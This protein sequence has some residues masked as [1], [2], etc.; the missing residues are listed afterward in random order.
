MSYGPYSKQEFYRDVLAEWDNPLNKTKSD[1][2]NALLRGKYSWKSLRAYYTSP[3][4]HWTAGYRLY[5][6]DWKGCGMD[7][8]Y[9]LTPVERKEWRISK[10]STRGAQRW[11]PAM[12][13][14]VTGAIRAMRNNKVNI[15]CKMKSQEVDFSSLRSCK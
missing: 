4:Y 10:H 2:T 12:Q 15:P 5:R 7:S 9:D 13:N 6:N 1:V 8:H 14:K 3:S 11:V